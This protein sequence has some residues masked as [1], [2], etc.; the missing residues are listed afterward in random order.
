MIEL[1]AD[2]AVVENV[3]WCRGNPDFRDNINVLLIVL[4]LHPSV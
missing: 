1:Q 2:G 4:L 3:A